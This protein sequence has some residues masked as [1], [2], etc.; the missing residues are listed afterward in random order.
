LLLPVLL[1]SFLDTLRNQPS[2]FFCLPGTLRAAGNPHG[3][4]VSRF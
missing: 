2:L 1:D 3:F 4:V